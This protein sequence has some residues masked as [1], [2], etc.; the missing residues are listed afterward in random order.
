[1]RI[2]FVQPVIP[3]YSVSFFNLLVEKSGFEVI[4][5]ADIKSS[6]Q[7]NQ[8]PEKTLFTAKHLQLKRLGPFFIRKGLNSKIKNDKPDLIVFNSDPRDLTQLFMMVKLALLQRKFLAW[9]MFHR[10]GKPILYTNCYYKTISRLCEYLLTYSAVGRDSLL[11]LGISKSKIIKIDTA[12]DEQA[13]MQ[14]ANKVTHKQLDE[15]K[16]INKLIGKKIVLQVVR[17]SKIKKPHLIVEAAEIIVEQ[18]PDV[19]FVL[20]GGG[21]LE[22][23][24][25]ELIV[26]KGLSNHFLVLGP[27]YDE[28]KLALW[29]LSANIFV[30]PTCIGLSAHHAMCY[31]LPIVTDNDLYQQASEFELIKDGL[32]GLIYDSGDISS[33]AS[34]ILLLLN[35]HEMNRFLSH[36]AKYTVKEIFT[37]ENKVFNMIKAIRAVKDSPQ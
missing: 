17:L 32:N 25:K 9:G 23:V 11:R 19:L 37:L 31:G 2:I 27:I 10:I 22:S 18:S 6:S 8:L 3:N 29:F 34:N 20:I 15:F 4:V 5:Y 16:I 36:N 21:E 1:M 33:M 13:A 12:I 7:L 24:I 30:V 35:N 26:S 28:S 14:Q